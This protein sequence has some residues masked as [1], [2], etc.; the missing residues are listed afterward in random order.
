MKSRFL[1][2]PL[3]LHTRFSTF[4]SPGIHADMVRD[5]ERSLGFARALGAVVKPGMRVID[6]GA[7]TGLLGLWALQAGAAHL[8]AIDASHMGSTLERTFAANGVTDRATAHAAHSSTVTLAEK[9]DVVVAEILGHIGI[10]EGILAACHD[11]KRRLAKADAAFIPSRC[12]VIAWP[13]W[14]PDFETEVAFWQSAPYG[15][16]LSAVVPLSRST[17]CVTETRNG[18][19]LAADAILAEHIIGDAPP[20][21]WHG[22]ASF[23]ASFPSAWNGFFMSFVADLSDG[24]ELG[25]EISENWKPVFLPIPAPARVAKGD[26]LT[27]SVDILDS[28]YRYSGQH[29]G[30]TWGVESPT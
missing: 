11:V 30:A 25:G 27:L 10:D 14:A 19:R 13:V 29:N 2:Y 1:G 24:N 12:R 8:D 21:I 16:D 17:T 23:T 3:A 4:S 5:G 9:A 22:E 26:T 28:A 7:G 15:F 18:Q 6:L 20:A